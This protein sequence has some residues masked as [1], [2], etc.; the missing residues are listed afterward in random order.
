MF[1]RAGK[2]WQRSF[3]QH[4]EY[5]YEPQTLCRWLEEAGFSRVEQFGDCRLFAPAEGEQRI[6]FAAYKEEMEP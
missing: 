1:R 4:C 2:L 6:Y 3:E 5:A